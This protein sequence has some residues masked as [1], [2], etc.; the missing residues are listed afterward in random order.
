LSDAF[1]VAL[2]GEVYHDE[3]GDTLG[4]AG[5]TSP[6]H[7]NP[8]AVES[9]TAEDFTLTLNYG[10]GTHL[11]FMFDNRLDVANQSLFP[12]NTLNTFSSTQ[13]T[14]TLGVIASTK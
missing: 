9:I 7:V 10:I 8:I 3:H 14:T 11:A 12:E 6:N 4:V 5:I 1:N 13:F 2:R